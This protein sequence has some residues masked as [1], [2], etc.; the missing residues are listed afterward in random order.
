MSTSQR[1]P[2]VRVA[3]LVAAVSIVAGLAMLLSSLNAGAAN[4]AARARPATAACQ[5]GS[6]VTWLNTQ[7]NGAA[8]TIFYTLNF[9]NLSTSA[10]TLRGYPGVSAV[11]LRGHQIGSAG[12]RLTVKPVRTITVRS[13]DTAHANL[14]IVEAGNF[15]GC[16]QM[17][18][19]G[20]RVFAPN[21]ARSQTDPFPFQ[22]CSNRGPVILKVSAVY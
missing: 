19:A 18:A 5:P 14:G 20:V 2:R 9:T 1:Q 6:M 17:T 4:A 12:G 8:G 15:S 7:G 22:A 13:G 21:Q 11:S 10:C 16:S 3:A